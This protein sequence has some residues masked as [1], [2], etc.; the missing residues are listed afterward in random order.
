MILNFKRNLLILFFL[1]FIKTITANK[2]PLTLENEFIKLIVNQNTQDL[3]RFA[4]ETTQ[5]D[6]VNE[7]DD[8]VPLI[9]GRPLPWTSFSSFKINNVI[10]IFGGE[11][12]KIKKRSKESIYFG[13]IIKQ[14]ISKN[15]IHTHAKLGPFY[16]KQ[17][18]GFFRHPN[19]KVFDSAYIRY[20]VV[21]E[22]DEDCSLALRIML[23]TMLGTNDAAPFRF[24]KAAITSE[25]Q[26]TSQNFIPYWQSFD[27]LSNPSVIAQGT[28][29]QSD[30]LEY[31]LPNRLLLSNWGH[32]VA[33][34]WNA[35]YQENRPFIRKGE[36]EQD[37]ALALYWNEYTFKPGESRKYETI[38]GLGGM[39]LTP[40]ELTLGLST[41]KNWNI[42]QKDPFLLMVYVL[43]A[44]GFDSLDTTI[45]VKL[46]EGFII[47][48]GKEKIFIK[49]LESGQVL[50]FPMMIA[51]DPKKVES[52]L[53]TIEISANSSSLENNRLIEQISLISPKQLK[54]HL[55]IDKKIFKRPKSTFVKSSLHV[56]NPGI[57]DINHI[58]ATL[59]LSSSNYLLPGF[60][61]PI[62]FFSLGPK[63]STDIDW[64]IKLDPNIT[65]NAEL[66]LH[67]DSGFDDQILKVNS[68]IEPNLNDF[69]FKISSL[70]L[71]KNDFFYLEIYLHE[72]LLL[73]N[74]NLEILFPD[75]LV[76]FQRQHPPISLVNENEEIY[77][78]H[79]ND[80]INFNLQKLAKVEPP[81]IFRIFFQATNIGKG[82]LRIFN[83]QKLIK[84][85][86]ISVQPML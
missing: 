20:E 50:Q 63:E 80:L 83:H 56:Q 75:H 79:E 12:K 76:K 70:P 65:K 2:A 23:D 7:K 27:S 64:L 44:G 59:I 62:K 45:N 82:D 47:Q 55:T 21:N 11:N 68:I 86:P 3:G 42:L 32:L 67:L 57:L 72:N 73:E 30:N 9:F 37:T 85:L 60:E 4:I 16:V 28:L 51:L 81:F 15:A 40:G 74:P 38:Y 41:P 58:K 22:S 5:G 14:Y 78:T 49:N 19:T 71:Y 53:Q 8:Y 36:S 52:G 26:F 18:L 34:P 48:N 1:F 77:F 43:N 13:K 25:R 66:T 54:S 69:H 84:V 17:E 10:Y 24:G 33:Y 35:N 61:K 6:P 46:P 39:K 31:T 29:L